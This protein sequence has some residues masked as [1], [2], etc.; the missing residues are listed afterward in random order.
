L[1]G[2]TVTGDWVD[3]PGG[4]L[5]TGTG[6]LRLRVESNDRLVKLSESIPYAASV[7]TRQGAPVASTGFNVRSRKQ[8]YAT[9]EPVVVDFSGFPGNN[10][11]WVT[12]VKATAATDSYGQFFYT[13]R[14]RDGS[15]TFD[16]LPAGEY[17]VRAYFNWPQDGYK[18]QGRYPFRVGEAASSGFY[19]RTQK[20]AYA[21]NKPIVVEYSGFPGGSQDW[22]T[23]VK[24]SASHDTYGQWFYTAGKRGGTFS[25]DGLSAGDYEARAYFNWPQGGY[26][27]QARYSFTVGD[28]R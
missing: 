18:V 16:A 13:D 25:F 28:G 15:V 7:W 23:V 10:A 5:Q 21:P 11:D 12:V 14:K 19:V 24:S 1:D 8:V 26:K 3:L 27:V 6:T 4:K 22:I 20:S 2:S 9:D 17:E